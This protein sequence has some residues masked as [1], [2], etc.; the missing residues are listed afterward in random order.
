MIHLPIASKVELDFRRS[1]VKIDHCQL[2]EKE[3]QYARMVANQIYQYNPAKLT[4]TPPPQTAQIVS[5]RART[6][7]LDPDHM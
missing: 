7:V 5:S 6:K 2:V 1:Q 4:V 3:S